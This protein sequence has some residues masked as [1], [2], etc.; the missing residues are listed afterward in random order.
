MTDYAV[1]GKKRSG[2][3]LFCIGLIRDAL[4]AGKRVATNMDVWPEKMLPALC[5][6]IIIRLPDCPTVEDME[7]LGRG[8]E[9]EYD[10]DRN[11]II[12]LDESS[13]FF[14]ARQWGDK[15]RQPLLDWLI[16]SGKLGWDVYYQMQGL[17]Q[18]DK[19]LRD[20]QVEYHVSVKRTDRW[21][22][23][24][25]TPLSK[26]VGLDLRIPRMHLGIYRH[27]TDHDAM[28]V[29]R[30]FYRAKDLYDAYDTNQIFNEGTELVG[31]DVIDFRA[32]YTYLPAAY[33]TKRIYTDKLQNQIDQINA[34]GQGANMAMKA[35]NTKK[36]EM[37][38]KAVL[39]TAA[40]V[41][42]LGWRFFSGGF[43]MP[44]GTQAISAVAPSMPSPLDKQPL[45]ETTKASLNLS[46]SQAFLDKLFTSYRPR[47]AAFITGKTKTGDTVNTGLVEFY[48]GDSLAERFTIAELRSFGCAVAV[49]Q[50]GIDV[51]TSNGSYSVSA[52]PRPH[53][54]PPKPDKSTVSNT[55]PV[56]SGGRVIS[57]TPA[58]NSDPNAQ[59]SPIL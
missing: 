37:M 59:E 13:K 45:P 2:K 52:W 46:P 39:L 43:S 35:K 31:R 4:M 42:F 20:T 5:R 44:T 49:K 26:L 28:V 7:A 3:G 48:D 32:T 12:V 30:K 10:D 6:G 14:N 50:Y 33:L 47:L 15:A 56:S 21:P 24:F 55:M 53:I 22:I 9:G 27:G 36:N 11:G 38:M 16:H 54:D 40:L 19:Q 29:D 18:I 1:T 25:I 8:Y 57:V 34:I 23:P 41:L 58:M 17:G 51:I